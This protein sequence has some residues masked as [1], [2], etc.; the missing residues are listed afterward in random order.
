VSQS[1]QQQVPEGYKRTEVGIIPEDWDVA[2][3]SQ[4]MKLL[5]GYGFKP[6]QWSLH[7]L[8]II[9]IQNLNDENAEF[10]Y[11]EGNIDAKFHVKK[12][13]LLFAWSGSK[14]SSFGARVWA[15]QPAVLNQHIFRVVPD[16]KSLTR[17]LSDLAP[18]ESA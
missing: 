9:R 4:K 3:I 13:D 6:S 14:G 2:P 1:T 8:P 5:N 7:G 17:S 12:G 16:K 15:R 18:S 11:F 10:N